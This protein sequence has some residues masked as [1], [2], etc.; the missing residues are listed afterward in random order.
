[1]PKKGDFIENMV[2]F[3]MFHD[4]KM[5]IFKNQDSFCILIK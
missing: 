3:Y 2:K 1:M 4:V 5:K